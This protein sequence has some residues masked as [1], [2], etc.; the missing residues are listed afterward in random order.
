MRVAV[1]FSGGKDS[2]FSAYVIKR[3]GWEVKYLVTMWPEVIDSWMFHHPCIGI[4]S[5]QANA[6]GIKHILKKTAGEKEEE[7]KDLLEALKPLAEKEE[8]DAIVTGA[9][10]SNYQKDRIDAIAKEL[11]VKHIS[12]L[13]HKNPEL[14]LREQVKNGFETIF[15]GVAAAGF[16]KSWLGRRI[17]ESAI[18]DLRALHEKFGVHMC[19]E[20]GEF[21]TLVLDCPIFRQKIEL[22]D[23]KKVWDENTASGYITAKGMLVEK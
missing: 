21:E 11:G 7:L 9:V 5:L 12:P 17:D 4:T 14:L 15:A 1:L 20:G 6:M 16:D 13:W 8:I 3:Q 22:M 23:V 18:E 19:G 10:D 2:T